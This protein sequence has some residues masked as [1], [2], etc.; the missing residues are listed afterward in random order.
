MIQ[1]THKLSTLFNQMSSNQ[2]AIYKISQEINDVEKTLAE[3]YKVKDALVTE[4]AVAVAIA[5]ENVEKKAVERVEAIAEAERVET[6]AAI[7]KWAW[8]IAGTESYSETESVETIAAIK[9]WAWEIAE[10]ESYSETE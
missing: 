5:R 9:K 3:L 10:A 7:R 6:N 8:A 4:Y 2:Y 1:T